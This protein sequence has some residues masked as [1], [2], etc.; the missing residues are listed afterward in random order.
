MQKMDRKLLLITV[1]I[2]FLL[3]LYIAIP[4]EVEGV[5]EYKAINGRMSGNTVAGILTSH[6]YSGNL[7]TDVEDEDFNQILFA[8]DKNVFVNESLHEQ[9]ERKYLNIDYIVNIHVSSND[10]INNVRKGE[11][12]AYLVSRED[13]NKAKIGEMVRYRVSKFEDYTIEKILE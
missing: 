5:V 4:V 7:L 3:F 10:P 2:I 1:I 13:F 8:E 12:F 6:E 9:M 11:S